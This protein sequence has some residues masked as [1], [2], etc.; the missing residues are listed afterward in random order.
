MNISYEEMIK[1]GLSFV[2]SKLNIDFKHSLKYGNDFWV[3]INVH[4]PSNYHLEEKHDIY[5]SDEK[6]ILLSD[7]V[8][9]C[10]QG[11][12]MFRLPQQIIDKYPLVG[13]HEF[14][15]QNQ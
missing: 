15:F 9:V 10:M 7:A 8:V 11:G 1:S 13:R 5:R 12:Q 2:I 6:L 4:R 3:G 14:S